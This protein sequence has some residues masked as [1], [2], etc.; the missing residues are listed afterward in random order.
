M[1]SPA[2]FYSGGMDAAAGYVAHVD[3]VL[4]AAEALLTPGPGDG[5]GLAQVGVPRPVDVP[6]GASGLSAGAAAAAQ[7]YAAAVGAANTAAAGSGS[8]VASAVEAAREAARAAELLRAVTQARAAALLPGADTPAGLRLLVE[9]M[10]VALMG[11]QEQIGASRVQL[12]ATAAQVRSTGA[13]WRA[14]LEP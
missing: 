9:T 7:R 10:A 11:M 13:G 12:S 8:A 1:R 3:R 6:G 14:V 5:D 4:A 2:T